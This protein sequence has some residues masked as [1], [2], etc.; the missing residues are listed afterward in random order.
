M[1]SRARLVATIPPYFAAGARH[2][3]P[4]L[5]WGGRRMLF[6]CRCLQLQAGELSTSEQAQKPKGKFVLEGETIY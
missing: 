5:G 2:F 6:L 4:R 1:I 3:E